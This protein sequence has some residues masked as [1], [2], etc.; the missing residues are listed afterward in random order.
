VTRPAAATVLAALALLS[1]CASPGGER[2]E[3]DAPAT[4]A[5]PAQ[6]RPAARATSAV[7][8]AEPWSYE[9]AS[10]QV[11]RTRHYRIY[12]TESDALLAGRLP[13]FLEMALEHYRTAL[14]PL[15]APDLRLDTYLM[16]NRTQWTRVTRRLLG[17]R[18]GPFLRIQRGGFATRGVG[19]Y[20]DLGA[21]D[22][23]AI[24][25]HEGWHQYTQRVFQ[26]RL[27]T[28]LEEG[29]ASYMEGH[30]WKGGTPVFLPWANLERF[31]RLRVM[32][33][34]GRGLPLAS[35][36]ESNGATGQA[37]EAGLDFYAQAWGV[38]HFLA[39]RRRA[40]LDRLLRD[41]AEGRLT[42]VVRA[43][44]ARESASIRDAGDLQRALF[45][46]Y[47]G[48]LAEAE[49]EYRAFAEAATRPGARDDVVA[50]RPP[51]ATLAGKET[52]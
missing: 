22:T 13:G 16:D 33:A 36:I 29:V 35:F 43:S 20:Y 52:R 51:A 47:F 5:A 32:E 11:V 4:A 49:A 34:R 28:W 39:A 12:T 46:T 23:M 14:T 26:E 18:A 45:E 50:G 9:G 6:P 44:A 21:F 1:G 38:T 40:G 30:R 19:V 27:P 3:S 10:G 8:S 41:A 15:P 31:D 48:P 2:A 37:E 7:L 17:G 25:A 24:A 42:R